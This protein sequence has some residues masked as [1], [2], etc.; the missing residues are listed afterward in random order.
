MMFLKWMVWQMKWTQG[1]Y[2]IVYNVWTTG[3]QNTEGKVRLQINSIN[4]LS[5]LIM[6]LNFLFIIS[7]LA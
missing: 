2:Y 6:C 5:F 1:L 3:L 4:D 7:I